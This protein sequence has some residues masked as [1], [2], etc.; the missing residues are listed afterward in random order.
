MISI[1][2]KKFIKIEEDTPSS[3]AR[4]QYGIL[5]GGAGICLNIVLFFIKIMAGIITGSLAIVADALNNLSDC[6]SSLIMILGYKVSGRKPDEEH[7]FGHGRAEYVTGLIISLVIVFMG[8]ELLRSSIVKVFNPV[9]VSYSKVAIVILV[10]SI[11]VK[12]YMYYYNMNYSKK[13]SSVA[14]SA[15]AYDSL[16]DCVATTMVL[17]SLV[18]N[19]Y[20]GFNL[21]GYCGAI[22]ALFII[23]TGATSAKDAIDPILGAKPDPEFVE[24]IKQ[25]VMSYDDVYGVHDLIVHEYG[26]SKMMITLH[27]EVLADGDFVKMHDTIDNIERRLNEV[28]GCT[29]VIHMDPVFINDESTERMKR[30]TTLVVK[31]VDE[32]LTIHDFRMVKGKKIKLIFDVL[33]P[34]E[35]TMSD[36]EVKEAILKKFAELPGEL[37]PVVVIDR[38]MS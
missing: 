10:I 30:F 32:S 7:P 15:T 21:D 11:F 14:M 22:V 33:V 1:L 18:I 29:A 37:K 26:A 28:L 36:A 5:L 6:G 34:F 38:P 31:G 2:E 19:E 16:S 24:K 13:L 25:F 12:M 17:L 8:I 9:E 20:T 27:A 3:D 4:R 35:L 23:Y